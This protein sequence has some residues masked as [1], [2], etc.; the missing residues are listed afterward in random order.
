MKLVH[1]A[2]T[3]LGMAQFNRIDPDTGMNLREKLI[4][5]NFL[6]SIDRILAL[7]PDVLVHAGDLFDQVRPKTMAYTTVLE[8]LDR[9]ADAGIPVVLVAGNHSMPKTRYTPSPFR[10]LEFHPAELH[11]AYRYRYEKVEIGDS[12]FH[13]IPNMI[14]PVDYRTAYDQV[15]C[16]SGRSNV[17]VTHGLASSL[18]ERRLNTVAEHEIDATMLSGGF[19][20]IALGHFHG[21][22]QVGSRAWYSGSTEYLSYGEIR[23]TKGGLL[24]DLGRKSIDS[25]PLVNTPMMDL[26][27]IDCQEEPSRAVPGLIKAAIEHGKPELISLAQVTVVCQSREQA[28]A[29]DH[30]ALA[31]ERER[32]LDLK[33]RTVI[34]EEDRPV[35]DEQD[36]RA[37]DYLAEFDVFLKRKNLAL[38]E[39]GF[40][41]EEGRAALLAAIRGDEDAT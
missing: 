39:A 21:Q 1:I 18:K 33:I 28:K 7:R 17:L 41:R 12:V 2:D 31:R 25:L 22:V 35:P 30:Q 5:G 4:Y 24:V 13:L 15:E 10:V 3:H 37:I 32:L 19:D 27:T 26:G 9:L 11:A 20:Y 23:D 16:D 6:Q 36:L 29:I 14:R 34:R 40:I 8:A 38:R